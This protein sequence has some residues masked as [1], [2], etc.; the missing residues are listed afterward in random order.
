[1]CLRG[2]WW[3]FFKGVCMGGVWF[4]CW[5]MDG[6]LLCCACMTGVPCGLFGIGA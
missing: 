3:C 6:Y 4:G 1:L 2:W 5:G